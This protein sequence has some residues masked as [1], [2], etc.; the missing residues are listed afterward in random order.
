MTDKIQ[1]SNIHAEKSPIDPRSRTCR[2]RNFG[3]NPNG[4]ITSRWPESCLNINEICIRYRR[5]DHE[6]NSEAGSVSKYSC[7]SAC[8]W[9]RQYIANTL[10]KREDGI[11][12]LST[13]D[14]A[15]RV[16]LVRTCSSYS[17]RMF[18]ILIHARCIITRCAITSL[19]P[20]LLFI[21]LM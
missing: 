4:S 9:S 18:D 10:C 8:T 12:L 19:K 1:L 16:I 13:N 14:E 6:P 5:R 17:H 7:L 3:G 21:K 11:Q 15:L 2:D 20:R